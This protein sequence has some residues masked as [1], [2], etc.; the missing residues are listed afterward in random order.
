MA[1]KHVQRLAVAMEKLLIAGSNMHSKIGS[2]MAQNETVAVQR[3]RLEAAS[4]RDRDTDL[5]IQ[6]H[7]EW[8]IRSTPLMHAPPTFCNFLQIM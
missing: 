5:K 8:R 3:D 6:E 7:R 2:M 1:G 4:A